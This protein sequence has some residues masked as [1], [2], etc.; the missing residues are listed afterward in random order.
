M[1]NLPVV[2]PAYSEDSLALNAQE[3]INLFVTADSVNPAR[4]EGRGASLQSTP[5]TSSVADTEEASC[6]ALIA[7]DNYIYGVFGDNLYEFQITSTNPITVT[8]TSRGT[9]NTSTGFCGITQDLNYVMIVDGTNGYTYKK[10]DNTF[11]VISDADYNDTATE[12]VYVGGYFFTPKPNSDQMYSSNLVDPTAWDALDFTTAER[13]GDKIVALAVV[14]GELWAL[15]TE[16]TEIYAASTT[17][18]AFPFDLVEGV[19]LKIGCGQAK[20]VLNIDDTL[21]WLDNRGFVVQ[22]TGYDVKPISTTPIS[23]AIQE[24]KDKSAI[25]YSIVDSGYRFYC[26]SFT[27]ENKTWCY[28]I[29]TGFWSEL[30]S[31]FDNQSNSDSQLIENY[32]T[33]HIIDHTVLH[34]GFCFGGSWA[35][36]DLFH[37]SQDYRTDDGQPIIRQRTTAHFFNEFKQIHVGKVEIQVEPGEGLTTGQGKDPQIMLQY[38]KDRGH[39]WSNELWRSLG[40]KGQYQQR[41]RWHRLGQARHW[42]YRFKVSDPVKVTILEASWEGR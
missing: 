10:S 41:V 12:V 36:G 42:T 26:L 3:C 2:G 13:F 25:A 27:A 5:G 22:A 35:S 23:A 37:I 31:T 18:T 14:R 4:P 28:N 19:D 40:A 1:P 33:K 38:S 24:Y 16:S 21:Y 15:G 9:L 32:Q 6:R 29:D 34:S 7:D 11:A 17:A 8:S 30:Q 39:T 20:S